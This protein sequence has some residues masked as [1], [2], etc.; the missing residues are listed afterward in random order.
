VKKESF[1][2]KDEHLKYTLGPVYVP[3]EV[4]AQGDFSTEDEIRKA[5]WGYMKKLQS[6]DSKLNKFAVELLDRII[7]EVREGNKVRIDMNKLEKRY[8][9]LQKQVGDM[10][11]DF[12]DELGT[13]VE[14][15]VCPN[16]IE[17]NDEKIEK[18][19]WLLGV[20]WTEKM[21]EKI[22]NGERIGYSMGGKG[23]R[24]PVGG[25]E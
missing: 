15:F 9:N 17:I 23:L 3:E 11:T 12:G 19:T 6:Q 16:D 5:A 22:L 25:E 14:S 21:F 7:K 10:H 20:H 18:G 13:V 2:K 4:D 24:V 8:D 1:I